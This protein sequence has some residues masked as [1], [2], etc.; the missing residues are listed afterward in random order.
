MKNLF[1]IFAVLVFVFASVGV[2]A[3]SKGKFGH[4]NSNELMRSMPGRDSIQTVLER[5]AKE[6]ETAFSAM[7]TEFQTKYQ[8][9]LANEKTFSELIRQA[10]QRELANLQERIVDFQESA[11][12]DLQ[13]KEAELFSP[14]IEKARKA[15]E[16]VAKANGYT[17][18]FDSS[19]GVLLYAE[20]SEDIMPLVKKKLGIN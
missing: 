4:I 3:Q 1:K 10:K 18:V 13:K 14:L 19:L 7:Q 17:Y 5:H 11:Q 6:L 2:S 9:F 16:D 8:D 15:I 12:E 20:P